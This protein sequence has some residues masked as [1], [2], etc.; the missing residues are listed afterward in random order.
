MLVLRLYVRPD[1]VLVKVSA[2]S[3]AVTVYSKDVILLA[4]L[5]VTLKVKSKFEPTV[6]EAGINIP[7]TET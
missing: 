5:F 2:L 7:D 6:A 1:K 4:P 3:P